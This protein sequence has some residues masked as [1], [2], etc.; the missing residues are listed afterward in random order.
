MKKLPLFIIIL[1]ALFLISPVMADDK[2]GQY[3]YIQVDSVF[4]DVIDL[5]KAVFDVNYQIDDNVKFLVL[6]LGKTDL[7][8]KLCDIFDLTNCRFEEVDMDHAR[9]YSDINSLN[10]G[11]GAYWFPERKFKIE[12]PNLTIRAYENYKIFDSVKDFPG[13]GYYYGNN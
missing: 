4:I 12:I 8:E 1:S 11:E 13:I 10:N 3:S 2:T 6:L 7:K 5:D 9:I